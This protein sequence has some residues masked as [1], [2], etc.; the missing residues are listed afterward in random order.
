MIWGFPSIFPLYFWVYTSEY[1]SEC[2]H[3]FR[4]NKHILAITAYKPARVHPLALFYVLGVSSKG[5]T[6]PHVPT[7]VPLKELP[8]PKL[9]NSWDITQLL[10][11]TWIA[12]S[13]L[14]KNEKMRKELNSVRPAQRRQWTNSQRLSL[15][16]WKYFQLY[17]RQMRDKSG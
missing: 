2:F 14:L 15:K 3:G 6:Y 7:S 11:Q 8:S 17:T 13:E 9:K 10:L 4:I 5:S 1:T 16:Y 12:C